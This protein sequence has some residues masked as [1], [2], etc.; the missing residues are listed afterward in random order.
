MLLNPNLSNSLP[1]DQ[2]NGAYPPGRQAP[3]HSVLNVQLDYDRIKDCAS[4]HAYLFGF[5]WVW[6]AFHLH[7]RRHH[8]PI[9]HHRRGRIRRK[10]RG[11]DRIAAVLAVYEVCRQLD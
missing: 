3:R 10:M 5:P 9:H 4:C 8:H 6:L 7:R 11:W 1:R 2:E